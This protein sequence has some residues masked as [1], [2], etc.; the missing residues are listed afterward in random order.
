MTLQA[1]FLQGF[2]RMTFLMLWTLLIHAN[3]EPLMISGFSPVTSYLIS[4]NGKESKLTPYFLQKCKV[5]ETQFHLLLSDVV[6]PQF[7][8]FLTEKFG[9]VKKMNEKEFL[10]FIINEQYD[11]SY[12][13]FIR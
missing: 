7:E 9:H 12:D 2:Q 1:G 8:D 11:S 3:G 5:L 6:Q 13:D 4:A 10:Q